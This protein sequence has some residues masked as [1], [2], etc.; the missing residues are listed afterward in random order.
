MIDSA[1]YLSKVGTL[2]C[3]GRIWAGSRLAPKREEIEGKITMLF[4]RDRSAPSRLLLTLAKP[5]VSGYRLPFDWTVAAFVESFEWSDEF[6]FTER[7][8]TWI[9]FDLDVDILIPRN[10]PIAAR[11]ILMVTEDLETE[12]ETTTD[13]DALDLETWSVGS[14]GSLTPQP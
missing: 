4:A 1:T 7:L 5:S 13:L 11:I 14:D 8:W 3:K 12:V 9:S 2:R 6:A 10:D